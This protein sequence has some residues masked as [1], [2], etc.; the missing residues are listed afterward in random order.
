MVSA[1]FL[2]TLLFWT[3]GLGTGEHRG[4]FDVMA[5][6]VTAT[7]AAV[8][9]F[10]LIWRGWPRKGSEPWQDRPLGLNLRAAL[11]ELSRPAIA[12]RLFAMGAI[13]GL[14]M[15]YII[16]TPLIFSAT[17]ERETSDVALMV[18]LV[19]G[20]E[21]PF[22]LALPLLSGRILWS[23]AAIHGFR[24]FDSR[25]KVL[26]EAEVDRVLA[27]RA[28]RHERVEG[29]GEQPDHHAGGRSCAEDPG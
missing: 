9:L 11:V 7:L 3:W 16:L 20:F 12:F 26:L 8:L 6:Y 2:L 13:G 21:V 5:V 4:G 14:P 1:V 23:H 17:P 28:P 18:G 29:G 25:E 19:A 10:A 24:D 22:M 15:L 27:P